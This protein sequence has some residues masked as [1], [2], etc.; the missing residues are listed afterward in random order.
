MSA[1]APAVTMAWDDKPTAAAGATSLGSASQSISA[2]ASMMTM[3]GG[4]VMPLGAM[5]GMASGTGRLNTTGMNFTGA[6]H[7]VEA[8]EGARGLG[9]VATGF[10]IGFGV[11][12]A[13]L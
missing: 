9:F 12:V 2:P 1:T 11:I 7:R 5:S 10:S 4:S 13:L 6:A 8:V 3:A